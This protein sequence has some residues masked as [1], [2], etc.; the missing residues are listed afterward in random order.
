M[1]Y[2]P[3]IPSDI[4]NVSFI[5]ILLSLSPVHIRTQEYPTTRNTQVQMHS[6]LKL[7][8][9]KGARYTGVIAEHTKLSCE[10]DLE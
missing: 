3:E 2:Y 8:S 9:Q 4:G 6:M 10:W 5:G 7:W 1:L